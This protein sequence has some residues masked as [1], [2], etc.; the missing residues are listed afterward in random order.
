MRRIKT[1]TIFEEEKSIRIEKS[2]G[3][4]DIVKGLFEEDKI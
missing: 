3:D 4:Y 2:R 1:W